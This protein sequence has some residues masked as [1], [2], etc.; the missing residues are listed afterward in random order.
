MRAALAALAALVVGCAV[1]PSTLT[2]E[3]TDWTA[4]ERA[5][6]ESAAL[7]VARLGI[8]VTIEPAQ[9]GET[10]TI[11]RASMPGH[12][13]GYS[14]LPIMI[15]AQAIRERHE[16]ST[17]LRETTA[18]EICHV[19]G[20]H[21]VDA[22]IMQADRGERATPLE[23]IGGRVMLQWSDADRAEARTAGLF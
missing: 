15:D 2:Y 11:A 17:L 19:Y 7:D 8:D 23:T 14:T 12:T 22:G 18:H 3:P 13:L 21:H 9:P 16:P 5:A 4:D 6:L 1:P 10:P 20:M